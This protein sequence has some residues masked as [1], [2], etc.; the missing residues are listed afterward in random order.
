[1]QNVTNY[2]R[3]LQTASYPFE[4]SRTNAHFS[5]NTSS[6]N[7]AMGGTFHFYK[8]CFETFAIVQT[9]SRSGRANT[10]TTHNALCDSSY[11]IHG[12]FRNA[13]QIAMGAVSA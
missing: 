10:N 8:R 9:E 13:R 12:S 7:P 5:A 2:A 11:F 4:V 6:P 3:S 1:M